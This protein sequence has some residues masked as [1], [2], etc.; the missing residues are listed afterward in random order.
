MLRISTALFICCLTIFSFAL[1]LFAADLKLGVNA[2]RGERRAT[3]RWNDLVQYL[4]VQLDQT[5]TLVPLHPSKVV[6]AAKDG[7]VDL[8]LSHAAHT[9]NLQER[10]KA[11]PIATLNGQLGPWFAGV[12]IAKKGS[13]IRT[14][15]DLKGKKVMSLKFSAAAGAYMFQTYHLFKQGIDPHK[16]FASI[17]WVPKQDDLV[18][19]VH[20]GLIDAGF[21]RSGILESMAREGEIDIANFEIV[22]QRHDDGLSLVHSTDLYPEWYFSVMPR[23]AAGVVGKIKAALLQLTETMPATQAADVHGF[24]DPMPLDGMK[25]LMKA[26]NLPPYKRYTVVAEPAK[27][28]LLSPSGR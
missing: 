6:T 19:A 21:I 22:D 5:V 9:L 23:V 17:R 13:G 7:Q 11:T 27:T 8:V 15:A 4:S 18:R 12:I 10:F 25:N 24:V 26:L 3:A 20:L 28:D 16:D 14:A 1:A 2:P